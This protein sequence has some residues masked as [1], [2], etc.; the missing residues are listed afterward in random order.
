MINS[1]KQMSID[2]TLEWLKNNTDAY[3]VTDVKED[4]ME[5][6]NIKALTE[7]ANS[8]KEIQSRFIPQIYDTVQYQK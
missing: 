1:L 4:N 6:G 8:S 5:N 2:D 7:F 3:I